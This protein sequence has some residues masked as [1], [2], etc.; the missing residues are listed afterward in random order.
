MPPLLELAH[1]D[2]TFGSGKRRARIVHAAVDVSFS[3][4]EGETLA[5]VGESGSGKTTVARIA[6]GLID[7]DA[8]AVRVNG[9]DLAGT[10]SSHRRELRRYVQPIFQDA[11]A[12]LNPRRT[13][14]STLAQAIRGGL[15]PSESRRQLERLAQEA[16]ER[17]G[18]TPG[19]EFLPRYPHELSGGQ[20]QRVAVAR[21]I[22]VRPKLVIADEPLSGADASIRGQLLNMLE[23]LQND[24]GLAYIL[25]THDI[26][27]AKAFAHR[28]IVM[29]NGQIVEQ[30]DPATVFER[31]SHPYTKQLIAAVPH[32]STATT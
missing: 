13:V 24:L 32:I 14:R 22:A 27:V 2:K 3:V 10:R 1:V 19:S 8:G 16:L 15:R 11:T 12:S 5:I 30:G 20:R 17:V 23:E 9:H 18:L 29:T 7:P 28:V 6:L 26:S 21:A 31:P 4:S 25:I